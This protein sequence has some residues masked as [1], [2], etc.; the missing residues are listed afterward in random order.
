MQL[1]VGVP[2]PVGARVLQRGVGLAETLLGLAVASAMLVGVARIVSLG[3]K[4]LRAKNVAEQQAAFTTA[5]AQYF[6]SNKAAILKATEDGTGA[7]D[8]CVLDADPATGTGGTAANNT[9]KHTCAFDV[10][11]LR[12]KKAIPESFSPTNIY[13]QKWTAIV[14]QVYDGTT[15]TGDAEMLIVAARNGGAERSVS[16]LRELAAT[17]SLVGGN[18]GFIPDADKSV[19][20]WDAVAGKYEACGTQGGWKADVADFVNSP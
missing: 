7:A 6:V 16:D 15:A 14:R 13:N 11:W 10:D 8:H 9:V 3:Q 12:W 18:G 5:A 19:C 1:K 2:A 20:V 17:A 4:D